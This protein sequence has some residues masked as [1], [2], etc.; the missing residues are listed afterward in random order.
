MAEGEEKMQKGIGQ[1]TPVDKLGENANQAGD[2]PMCDLNKAGGCCKADPKKC[3]GY[4]P[5][6]D[7]HEELACSKFDH[8][9]ADVN[10]YDN[11]NK[12]EVLLG[13]VNN[14]V[15]NDGEYRQQCCTK[16]LRC[17]VWK[18]PSKRI[19]EATASGAK[20]FT[21]LAA[22]LVYVIHALYK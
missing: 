7:G 16:R 5:P 17:V 6:K 22:A 10:F 4:P 18:D 14:L 19:P 12:T 3:A 8:E 21:T 11:E 1:F 15:N 20:S 2:H 13:K 9:F